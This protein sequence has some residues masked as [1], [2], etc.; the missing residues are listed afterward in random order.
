MTHGIDAERYTEEF[1]RNPAPFQERTFR[2]CYYDN[3]SGGG[4]N[5]PEI[6]YPFVRELLSW[7]EMNNAHHT[8]KTKYRKAKDPCG[9]VGIGE[10]SG[11]FPKNGFTRT[12]RRTL[13]CGWGY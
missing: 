3:V 6:L 2:V 8:I 1:A 7:V 9:G 12:T 11:Y 4:Q 10:G 5:P 13:R